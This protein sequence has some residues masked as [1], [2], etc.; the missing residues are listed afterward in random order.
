MKELK[1]FILLLIF[2]FIGFPQLSRAQAIINLHEGS[3]IDL[4]DQDLDYTVV[5]VGNSPNTTIA[6]V[7]GQSSITGDLG[8]F[9]GLITVQ[10]SSTLFYNPTASNAYKIYI[11]SLSRFVVA[12]SLGL[13]PIVEFEG[14]SPIIRILADNAF[15][16]NFSILPSGS[17]GIFEYGDG[18]SVFN[19][20]FKKDDIRLNNKVN[21]IKVNNNTTLTILP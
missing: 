19:L 1:L 20:S 18:V 12:C 10:N 14:A 21:L 7:G 5:S 16:D 6:A 3:S 2:I 9:Y 11:E 8:G 15:G 17:S 4:L 13:N